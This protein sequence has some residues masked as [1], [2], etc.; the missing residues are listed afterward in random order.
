MRIIDNFLEKDHLDAILTVVD[1]L[2]FP[3][4]YR[5]YSSY[6]DGKDKVPQ[7]AHIFY[8][9]DRINSEYFDLLIPVLHK[10]EDSTGYKVKRIHR[11]K[12]NMLMDQNHKE[13]DIKMAIH[14]DI[15]AEGKDK[16]YKHWVSL[17]LYLDD[18]DGDTLIYEGDDVVKRVT[19]KRNRAFIFQSS[20]VHNATPPK[21]NH[22]R[23]VIN[24]ILETER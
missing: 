24:F 11:I 8:T 14:K 5:Q 2:Y 15:P 20:L 17:I 7:L 16:D 19:P 23:K 6:E 3:W 22:T 13:D 10:F 21:K 9:D 12:A 4:F 18:S 1:G